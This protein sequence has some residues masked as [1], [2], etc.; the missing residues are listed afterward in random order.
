MSTP[1]IRPARLEDAAF[2][3]PLINRATEGLTETFWAD[4]A[5]PGQDLW[6]YGLQRVQDENS[7]ISYTNTW[8]AEWEATAAGCLIMHQIAETPEPVDPSVPPMFLPLLELE[9]QAPGTGY[10]FVVATLA[11]KS[12]HGIGSALLKFAES[13]KGPN[14]N[15]LIV[16]DNNIRAHALYQRLGY[17]DVSSKK[18]VKGNWQ[19]NGENWILMIKP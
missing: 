10:I 3:V 19:S 7:G 8:V 13:N 15:S 2:L 12:S 18:M 5:E 16:A 1:L 4:L 11:E 9:N 17:Q 6:E 14:G